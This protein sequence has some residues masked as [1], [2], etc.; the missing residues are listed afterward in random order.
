MY[1]QEPRITDEFKLY[2][3]KLKGNETSLMKGTLNTHGGV[4]TYVYEVIT[5]TDIINTHLCDW[6]FSE[7]IINI[8]L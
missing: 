6:F 4:V 5:K 8:N 7:M 3:N 1:I 2:L